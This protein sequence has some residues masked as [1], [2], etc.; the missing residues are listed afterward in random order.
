MIL[1]Y[2]AF[3]FLGGALLAPW[4]Y[5]LV[6]WLAKSSATFE[7][8]AG[9][10]FHRYVNRCFLIFAFAGLYPFLRVLGVRSW[11]SVGLARVP[12]RLRQGGLGFAVGFASLAVV[13]LGTLTLGGR[14]FESGLEPSKWLARAGSAA[15]TA[16][17]VG[18][19]EELLFRG[20]LFAALRREGTLAR[21]VIVSSGVYALVHFLQRPIWP[22][23]VLWYSGLALLPTKLHGF[24]EFDAMIPGFLSL[25][26]AGV[27]LAVAFERTGSIFFS[28]G[29]HPGWIFWLKFYRF[30]TRDSNRAPWFWGTGELIDGWFALLLLTIVGFGVA[31]FL[32]PNPTP[33]TDTL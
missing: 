17:V 15:A 20:A 16:L 30:A 10:P 23:E 8:L 22:G 33:P 24:V 11:A 27:I 12:G 32:R 25:M 13:A 18:C 3:V 7:P 2:L 31:R 6:Q 26:L 5:L 14:A 21:A 9:A 4:L 29:L 28:I 1:L 19:L